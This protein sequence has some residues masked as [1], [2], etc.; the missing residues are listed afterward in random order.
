M[1]DS[2]I[3]A[4]AGDTPCLQSNSSLTR[5]GGGVINSDLRSYL[6]QIETRHP[7][8]YIRLSTPFAPYLE[9]TACIFALHEKQQNPVVYFENISGSSF[10]LVTNAMSSRARLAMA[11][12][13][14]EARFLPELISRMERPIPPRSVTHAPVQE[15]C[16]GADGI[17][18]KSFPILTQF[19]EHNA[20]YIS[21]A[22]IIKTEVIGLLSQRALLDAA[23]RYLKISDFDVNRF[24]E[25]RLGNA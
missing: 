3:A 8:D 22:A 18:L 17:N 24:L 23:V 16:M 2:I 20:P 4:I 12:G 13:I 14:P 15:N 10:P 19:P 1:I 7:R 25:A 9:V 5:G 6:R 11:L 21:G